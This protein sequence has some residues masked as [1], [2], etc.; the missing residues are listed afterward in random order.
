MSRKA[1]DPTS[2]PQL[3]TESEE[4]PEKARGS[5][6]R[7]SELHDPGGGLL[8]YSRT[9]W[10]PPVGALHRKRGQG[11]PGSQEPRGGRCLKRAGLNVLFFKCLLGSRQAAGGGGESWPRPPGP[12]WRLR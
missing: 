8:R 2:E 7:A 11:L 5:G 3:C 9:L 12:P 1:G 4:G 10:G 6:E